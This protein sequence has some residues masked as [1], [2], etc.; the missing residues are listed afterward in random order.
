[1]TTIREHIQKCIKRNEDRNRRLKIL[2]EALP[3]L[4]QEIDPAQLASDE[5]G[6]IVEMGIDRFLHEEMDMNSMALRRILGC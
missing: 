6:R 4:D 1:M 5:Y 3:N 2:L